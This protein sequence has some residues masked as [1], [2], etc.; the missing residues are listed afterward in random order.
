M[1]NFCCTA[2]WLSHT[3]ISFHIL[4]H[5]HFSQDIKSSSLSYTVGPC[6]LSK[7][8]LLG[9]F[10]AYSLINLFNQFFL[11]LVPIIFLVECQVLCIQWWTRWT[12]FWLFPHNSQN[13]QA[14]NKVKMRYAQFFSSTLIG[15]LD[16]VHSF[17]LFSFP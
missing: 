5:Y 3:C 8:L 7:S 6:H 14:V 10:L 17:Y 12:R 13:H 2:W 1:F 9:H 16:P 11:K 4:F 15:S